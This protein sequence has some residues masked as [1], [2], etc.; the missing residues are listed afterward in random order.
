MGYLLG[1]VLVAAAPCPLLWYCWLALCQTQ[2]PPAPCP[3]PQLTTEVQQLLESMGS[4]ISGAVSNLGGNI[5]SLLN[6]GMAAAGT[7]AGAV[8]GVKAA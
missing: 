8:G 2:P 3:V 6:S 1:A 4:G 7:G 5:A